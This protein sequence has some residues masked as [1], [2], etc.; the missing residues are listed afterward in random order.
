MASKGRARRS[1]SSRGP[2]RAALT[3][4]RALST[5]DV[6][7]CAR[8]G[9][10]RATGA[11]RIVRVGSGARSFV[12]PARRRVVGAAS[13]GS[14]GAPRGRGTRRFTSSARRERRPGTQRVVEHFHGR[15]RLA[16]T[17][18]N[19]PP[20]AWKARA[21]HGIDFPASL[22]SAACTRAP[23]E[24]ATSTRHRRRATAPEPGKGRTPPRLA[25]QMCATLRRRPG[26]VRAAR[27]EY[28]R[29]EEGTGRR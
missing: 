19:A 28:Q 20:G 12:R 27:V 9:A 10:R 23:R 29:I 17:P 18:G 16:P 4:E 13:R 14:A 11:H 7:E 1:I 15:P 26:R 2:A 24:R 25:R 3:V 22:G 5:L 8:S 6:R 21:R